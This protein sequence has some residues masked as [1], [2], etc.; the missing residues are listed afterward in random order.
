MK[1]GDPTISDRINFLD[2]NRLIGKQHYSYDDKIH[3]NE[4]G[5]NLLAKAIVQSFEMTE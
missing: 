2:V 1:I 5:K 3:L 4:M